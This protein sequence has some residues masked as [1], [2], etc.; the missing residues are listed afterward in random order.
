MNQ[1]EMASKNLQTQLEIYKTLYYNLESV[2]DKMCEA[3]QSSY[4][5]I[6]DTKYLKIGPHDTERVLTMS[7]E[8]WLR[9]FGPLNDIRNSTNIRYWKEVSEKYSR[10]QLLQQVLKTLQ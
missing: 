3:V 9:V 4:L 10:N 5:D 8:D 7:K 2:V 6:M 1:E